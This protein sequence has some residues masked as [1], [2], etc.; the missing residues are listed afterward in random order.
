MQRS[1]IQSLGITNLAA[2]GFRTDE[3]ER[4]VLAE[5]FKRLV[6]RPSI[7]IAQPNGRGVNLPAWSRCGSERMPSCSDRSVRSIGTH[8]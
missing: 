1:L 4:S 6:V 7:R 8:E 5:P 2:K 3:A